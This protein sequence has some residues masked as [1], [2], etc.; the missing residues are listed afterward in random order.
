MKLPTGGPRT[1]GSPQG[2]GEIILIKSVIKE[3]T[4][5]NLS[6]KVNSFLNVNENCP[7]K[8]DS[9]IEFRRKE[10]MEMRCRI[11]CRK[12]VPFGCLSIIAPYSNCRRHC[13][14]VGVC[15][16]MYVW[17]DTGVHMDDIALIDGFHIVAVSVATHPRAQSV[18]FFFPLSP[19]P[20]PSI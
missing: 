5:G 17:V 6:C 12:S 2:R 14:N 15:V 1:T 18:K 9:S 10:T 19:P 16:W 4:E 11:S 13:T 8:N 7:Y 20:L 3:D